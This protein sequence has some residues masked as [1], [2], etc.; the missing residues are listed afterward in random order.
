M[1]RLKIVTVLQTRL[2]YGKLNDFA[3]NKYEKLQVMKL[4]TL[5]KIFDNCCMKNKVF[6]I[7]NGKLLKKCSEGHGCL[8]QMFSDP[9]LPYQGFFYI[10]LK[11]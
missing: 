11:Q 5:N 6:Q 10:W 4:R 7:I 2:V 8:Y 9:K 3:V 1:S